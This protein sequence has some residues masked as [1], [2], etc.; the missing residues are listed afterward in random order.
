MHILCVCFWVHLCL[1]IC[2]FAFV[3]VIFCFTYSQVI[4]GESVCLYYSRVRET[5]WRLGSVDCIGGGAVE[6]G[7]LVDW[8]ACVCATID[9]PSPTAIWSAT[10]AHFKCSVNSCSS[11]NTQST[12]SAYCMCVD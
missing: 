6:C 10:F 1:H 4:V 9:Y 5:R 11:D 7:K 8:A 3:H 12:S 2:V